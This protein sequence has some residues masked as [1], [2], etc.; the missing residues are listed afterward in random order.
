MTSAEWADA[1]R[2]EPRMSRRDLAL[3]STFDPR[4]DDTAEPAAHLMPAPGVDVMGVFAAEVEAARDRKYRELA[5]LC[6]ECSAYT[7]ED[8]AAPSCGAH[9][10]CVPCYATSDFRCRECERVWA[11]V[12]E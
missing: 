6:N 3:M 12:G 8:D 1:A 9:R 11:E 2:D 10:V 7:H 4:E 5:D